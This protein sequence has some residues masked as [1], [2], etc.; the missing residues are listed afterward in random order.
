[1]TIRSKSEE[2][3][4]V[5]QASCRLTR[6]ELEFS[7]PWCKA[8]GRPDGGNHVRSFRL[9]F[10]SMLVA[11]A[12]FWAGQAQAASDSWKADTAGNWNAVGS[13]LGAQI[14]GS[15]SSDNSDVATFSFTLTGDRIVTVDA[16]RYIGC[17]SFGNGAAFKYTLSG[18]SLYLNSG[19][20]I[21]SLGG[22]GNHTDTIST[23]IR[24]DGENGTATFT[25]GATSPS[26]VLSIGAVT[27]NSSGAN[28]ST[29]T[30][31]GVNT[32]LNVITGIIGDG[33]SGGKLALVKG[34]SGTWVL[35][36][37]NT[38][39]GGLTLNA[40]T[41]TLQNATALGGG[42]GTFAIAGGTLDSGTV[43]LV[44][45][46]NNPQNW[47][48]NFAFT[49][50]QNLNLGTGAVAMNASRQVT[51][52][53]NTLTVGGVISGAGFGLT[54]AGAGTLTLNGSAV[55][56]FNGGLTVNGGTN[57]LDF[58]NLAT[59]TDLIN[60]SNT[61][62]MGNGTLRIK[63]KSAGSTS[64]T[65]S[66][67]TQNAGAGQILV[68][69]NG[70]AGTT[71]TLGSIAATNA[72]RS[73]LVGQ[74]AAGTVTITTTSSKDAQGIYGGRVVYTSDGGTTVDWATTA[75]G[76][77]AYILGA[78]GT[79]FGSYETM[80]AGSSTN[81]LNETTG[82][83]ALTGNHRHNSLKITTGATLS[84]AYTLNLNSG[85]LLSVG[86]GAS[87][88]S[89]G[90]ITA[91]Y[92]FN[93]AF[94]LIVHQYN[95]AGLTMSGMIID[96][97]SN[98]TSLTKSG[99]QT[100]TLSGA[101]T[102]SGGITLNQGTL[103]IANTSAL[104][105][106]TLTINGGALD[107]NTDITL[108]NN[109][110]NWNGDFIGVTYRNITFGNG[111]VTINNSTRTVKVLNTGGNRGVLTI[112]GTITD[113][114]SGYG[115]TKDGASTGTLIITGTIAYSGVTTLN[116]GTLTLSGANTGNGGVTLNVGT[117]Y[118]NNA[119][120]L[121]TGM[122]T[123]NGG[124]I[125]QT[126]GSSVTVST[127]TPI[128]WCADVAY[129][130]ST[131]GL[132][133]GPGTVT[134]NGPA[135][136]RAVNL[137]STAYLNP[138]TFGGTIQ[139][140]T[141]SGV[142]IYGAD[143]QAIL[144]LS[145]T[146]T[147]TGNTYIAARQSILRA[148]DGVGLPANSLLTIDAGS[149]ETGIDLVRP[150][151]S[152]AGHYMR[153]NATGT[154]NGQPG[155]SAYGGSVRICFGTL[156]VPEALTWGTPPFSPANLIL[157][158]ATA[159]NTLD[160]R[161]NIALGNSARIIDNRATNP[162]AIATL[163]GVLSSSGASGGLTKNG[164]G[165]LVLSGANTFAG[166][167]LV[168]AGTLSIPTI[169][170]AG[171]NGPLGNS[172]LAV[173]LAGGSTFEYSGATAGSTKKFTIG[174]PTTFQIDDAGT[175]LTLSGAIDGAGYLAKTGL[176]TLILS[177]ANTYSGGA[178]IN[179]GILKLST[180]N[181]FSGD[182]TINTGTITLADQYAVQNSTVFMNGGGIVFDSSVG[183]NVF[184]IGGLKG[185]TS[186]A[187]VNNAMNPIA[188]TIGGNNQDTAYYG[189]LSGGGSLT[190]TGTGTLTLN[191]AN[192]FTGG[193]TISVGTLLFRNTA[194]LP[195]YATA[196]LPVGN[197]GTLAVCAG[198]PSPSEWASTEIDT[199]LANGNI[200][201][202]AGAFFGIS[203]GSGDFTYGTS[204]TNANMGLA[205]L[206]A[207][208]LTLTNANTFVG[209]LAVKGG[210]NMFDFGSMATPTDMVNS[211]NALTLW[212]GTLRLKG[213]SSGSTSQTLGNLTQNS[214]GGQILLDANG[215][216]GTTLNLG[217]LTAATAGGSLLLGKAAGAGGGTVTITTTSAADGMGIYGGRAIFTSDGGTTVDWAA[218]VSGGSPYTL[219]AY[220]GYETAEGNWRNLSTTTNVSLSAAPTAMDDTTMNSLKLSGGTYNVTINATKTLVLSSGGLLISGAAV[221]TITGGT[222]KGSSG[223]DLVVHHYGSGAL[224]IASVIADNGSA[225]AL[226]KSGPGTL[227][228]S[229]TS[230][231]Y[232]GKTIVNG[233]TL[234][235]AS[236][237]SL[238]P[239]G[240]LLPD[241][242]TLNGGTLR[243]DTEQRSFAN[244]K[245]FGITIGPNGGAIT[246]G[247]SGFRVV[248]AAVSG[249]GNLTLN[250][251][252]VI[253]MNST[254]YGTWTGGLNS[255]SG[256]LILASGSLRCQGALV[257]QYA[258][259]DTGGGILDAQN[260]TSLTI[261]GLK[262]SGNINIASRALTVGNNN[263]DTAYSGV[264]SGAAGTLTK[265]GIGTLTMTA[266]AN[267]FTGPLTVQ[268]G[269]LAIGSVNSN[270]IAGPLGQS[271]NAVTLGYTNGVSGILRLTGTSAAYSSD[272]PFALAAGG[273]GVFQ[274]D[275]AGTTQTV[276]G[277]ISGAG[278]LTKTGAGGLILSGTNTF[279]GPVTVSAGM[280][281]GYYGSAAGTLT[282][283]SGATLSPGLGA[284]SYGTFTNTGNAI[285]ESGSALEINVGGTSN[286]LVTVG[287]TM[288]LD[289]TLNIVGQSP[290][291]SVSYEIVR[292]AG[293]LS[294][295]FAATNGVPAGYSLVYDAN[296]VKIVRDPSPII[297]V[298]G[299]NGVLIAMGSSSPSLALGTDFGYDAVGTAWTNTFVVTNVGA[300]TLTLSGAPVVLSGNADFTVNPQP[301]TTV[302]SSNSVSFSIVFTPTA[303]LSR[304]GMVTIASD[305]AS[306][307]PYT[308]AIRGGPLNGIWTNNLSGYWSGVTNWLDSGMP[309]GATYTAS[310]VTNIT[311]ARTVTNDMAGLSIG[312]LNFEDTVASHDWT[313][314]GNQITLDN[315][316]NGSTI[317][318]SNQTAIIS[319]I[320]AGAETIT[321]SGSG[322]LNLNNA[323]NTFSGK[324]IVNGG[325][326]YIGVNAG[327]TLGT[328]ISSLVRDQITLNGGTIDGNSTT[329]ASSLDYRGITLGPGGGTIKV[330][331]WAA[332]ISG[333]G[334]LTIT[335]GNF[336]L[337]GGSPSG[338]IGPYDS[339]YSGDTIILSGGS[340]CPYRSLSM[341]NSTLDLSQ[342]V[343]GLNN[344]NGTSPIYLGGLKGTQNEALPNVAG[345]IYI[346]NNN[347]NTTYS[348]VLS[349]GTGP[350][351]KIG[352]GTLTFTGA[353]SYTGP[354]AVN[355]GTLTLS[356]ANGAIASST[357]ITI[358]GAGILKLDNTSAANNGNRVGA[359][360]I[361]MSGGTFMFTNNAGAVN[362][363]ETVGALTNAAGANVISVAQSAVGQ[364]STLTFSSLTR[365]AGT[366][367]FVGTGLGVD[368][369]N[370][371]LITGQANG[372]I[373][374]WAT[375]NGTD[376]AAYDS[377][378]GVYAYSGYTDIA[379]RNS[380]IT[381]ND[382]DSI[383]ISLTNATPGNI[384]LSSDITIINSLLQNYTQPSTVD[385]ASK[386]LRTANITIGSGMEAL[387]V[388]AAVNAGNLT[389]SSAGGELTLNNYSTSTLTIN[390]VIADNTSASGLNKGGSGT[391]VLTATNTFTGSLAIG[392]G[393]LKLGSAGNG[394]FTPLGTAAAGTIVSASG[395]ALD[396]NGFTLTT[397]EPLTLNGT[398]ISNGGA[399]MN[400]SATAVT[401]SGPVT[402]GSATRINSAGG[403]ITFDVTSGDAIGGPGQNLTLG[404]SGNITLKDPI[405]TTTGSVT[406]DGAGTVTFSVLNTYSGGT[407]IGGGILNVNHTNS[408]GTAGNI[409][410]TGG[411]LQFGSGVNNAAPNWGARIQNSTAAISLDSNGQTVVLTGGIPV[412]GSQGLTKLGGG[413]LVLSGANAYTGTSTISAGTLQAN[414]ATALGNG[415][416]IVFTGGALQF[417]S[418]VNNTTLAWG[419][420]IKSSTGP[421]VMDS[422]GQTVTLTGNI[423]GSNTGGMTKNGSGTLTL[424]GTNSFAGATTVNAGVVQL[425]VTNSLAVST[426]ITVAGGATLCLSTN[427]CL[428]TNS[429]VSLNGSY[430]KMILSNTVVQTVLGLNINGVTQSKGTW[431]ASGSGCQHTNNNCFAG[432]GL[433]NV[434]SDP[435]DPYFWSL[436]QTNVV[437]Q[438]DGGL[439]GITYKVYGI[440]SNMTNTATLLYQINNVTSFTFIDTNALGSVDRRF[441]RVVES[442]SGVDTTNAIIF[443]AFRKQLDPGG[444]YKYALGIDY[445]SFNR[446][447]STL[448]G[449]LAQGLTGNNTKNSADLFYLLDSAG[450]WAM[451]YL[452]GSRVWREY[453]TDNLINTQVL[454]WQSFWIKRRSSGSTANP[455]Y[456]GYCF[457]NALPMIFRSND[458][459]MITWALSRDRKESDGAQQ[460][461]GFAAA[462][463]QKGGSWLNSDVL[464]VGDGAALRFYYLNT[465]G[466]WCPVGSTTP[467]SDV[468][469]HVGEAYYYMHRGTGM[470]WTVTGP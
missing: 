147:Y 381:S 387:T 408:L 379:Y 149:F 126:L 128:N 314:T 171:A 182:T 396:L 351:I 160:F 246:E 150:G 284:N 249:S 98:P 302:A 96:N 440:N 51:V 79:A 336:R 340:V 122:F 19:G 277:V 459:H 271:A 47:N 118:I 183:G 463:G 385:T 240:S 74:A 105:T 224:T 71:L 383:R 45:T 335:A 77:S 374:S 226:T 353:N 458:W 309:Q 299:T 350:L 163:S 124:T 39:T 420:R 92:N 269:T 465:S 27:G 321:K 339:T 413:T 362:Y 20:V 145:G 192:T 264:L 54:K 236:W 347:Q 346:G 244:A 94:D 316:G 446:L 461:W 297:N 444:W 131:G 202:A 451:C 366:I 412:N 410:F 416:D 333:S 320:L 292:S 406:K 355:G 265:I 35:S 83:L 267:T 133:L 428:P 90:F 389:T 303:N 37:A 466:R 285:L 268:S 107:S 405:G 438:V 375:V 261:G 402:L 157:N 186:M 252:T 196:A 221:P 232:T 136:L 248:A 338:H 415:G 391:V 120:A 64:Q 14:P 460:G 295:I 205:K 164:V 15:T 393:T 456:A 6:Q 2:V 4:F 162:S 386:I 201:F 65:L 359:V 423:S 337:D 178:T 357:G 342:A 369:R 76:G 177:G 454:P 219:S 198:V 364:T 215:G 5:S 290:Y 404:G 106:G 400:S 427:N 287:G 53:T 289:G 234:A 67:V 165:T 330:G 442:E 85:G 263:R 203:T 470:T 306:H 62:T 368:N 87:T 146:N 148:D 194:S 228:I 179:N 322:T 328:V 291:M 17:I 143:K 247:G 431:G 449:Q 50:T 181:T 207:N 372:L 388:G 49:G 193:I 394:T 325:T 259:I 58:A 115:L 7:L 390:A 243:L 48:G 52:N 100:L 380:T 315:S 304:T 239:A 197:G 88:I 422:N 377:T 185:T 41:L 436:D 298:L 361:T 204:L 121:G 33:A 217:T 103:M 354:T 468:N 180:A 281:G 360:P 206:G 82:T 450:N 129:A 154:G 432:P 376:L 173:S 30:L 352:T 78:Y 429:V 125:A 311:A 395:A 301:G 439:A 447:D 418:V 210:T 112:G 59:P 384:A 307:S 411:T 457:T 241:R 373:G 349:G 435:H 89:V 184:T 467:A 111:L 166:P 156:A 151:G 97:G 296:S 176:G 13:W 189:N 278:A 326:L 266:N 257:W 63:G 255:F 28:V 275:N 170:D 331:Q 356:G 175:T 12:A 283:K 36:G 43:N 66:N 161:N 343:N 421:I 424:S 256:D 167:L 199:L 26:S 464:T 452:D 80:V 448:G 38:F 398:G 3:G 86:A 139:N 99:P 113:N 10:L 101:N 324:I 18:G 367:N 23:A 69:P 282:N 1:M 172:A 222:L 469:F 455:I 227:V 262:G 434:Y 223:S 433:L 208:T 60:S 22:N 407:T 453:S 403:S 159:N 317:L 9:L 310:F 40:G 216:G 312:N 116:A 329:W 443:T 213:K 300:T 308:F 142:A 397:V 229:Q 245:N 32:N 462:G 231:T 319:C 93:S 61:V 419:T 211:G 119:E 132:N 370:K 272:K 140:G 169:N 104:G 218:T 286:D 251:G 237:T 345:G 378:L 55:N 72:G 254:D 168:N 134:L 332:P 392:A 327:G 73:L 425:G 187:L 57:L 109:P 318:V 138:L 84:G 233:G 417:G 24:I 313:L 288:S 117:L 358:S 430:G 137:P 174:N 399:L 235:I 127:A 348:G 371:I 108:G 190:K 250:T 56:T 212:G 42:A 130:N 294:G 114:G 214:G 225:T 195:D 25:A 334:N 191:G 188:L 200:T 270:N 155:F 46:A 102:F 260:S 414:H 158:D 95:T 409:A 365:T 437:L 242:I 279:T 230:D 274:V 209:G 293:A 220:A 445:G 91:D 81:T 323:N 110:Q 363:S 401:W 16:G 258:T 441:Y 153:V 44:L 144:V 31:N 344:I 152:T 341:Q 11:V 21:Q 238:G 29:L 382:V 70:G 280:L 253:E 276:S 34:G 123:I 141:A 68:D 135:G 8:M 426:N 305:D 75:S 273:I